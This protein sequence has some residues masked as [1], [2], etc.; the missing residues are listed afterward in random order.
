MNHD[1]STIFKLPPPR[2]KSD[3]SVEEA[4]AR[5]RSMRE[6]SG[7]AIGLGDLSQLLWA[8]QGITGA[9]DLRAAPSAGATY[10]LETYAVVARV[11]GL[12][13]GIYKYR[14]P[15]HSLARTHD[16]DIFE[17]LATAC[18]G[19]GCV[20]GAAAVIVLAA[21]HERTTRVYLNRG[22]RYIDNEVGHVA[23]NVHLQAVALGLGTV[24][25]GAFNDAAVEMALRLGSEEKVMYLVPVGK[26]I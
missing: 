3:V 13:A 10:P 9:G 22:M 12:E 6:Y 1:S 24:A 23:E 17:K 2:E 16:G 15:E 18:L 8:A 7:D 19:Q 20:R 4:I 26:P 5:R 11:A 21:V 25:V 14:P